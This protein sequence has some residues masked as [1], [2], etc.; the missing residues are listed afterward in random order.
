M[1]VGERG[2]AYLGLLAAVAIL[3]V[4]MVAV[5]EMWTATAQRQRLNQI[6]WIG[7]QFV[8]AITSYYE[9]APGSLKQHPSSLDELVNDK[10]F[11]TVRRHLRQIYINPLTGTREWDVMRGADGRIV[12]IRVVVPMP[13]ASVV[14]EYRRSP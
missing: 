3:G 11:L 14:R 6:D 7:E 4:G 10:R 2:F 9:L 13:G 12:G 5:S 8:Q 1:R